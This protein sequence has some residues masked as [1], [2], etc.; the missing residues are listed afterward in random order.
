M[1]D[2]ILEEIIVHSKK[3]KFENDPCRINWLLGKNKAYVNYC[4]L[5][6]FFL[7]T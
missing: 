7:N 3:K 2:L 6:F 1:Q 5:N 4:Y